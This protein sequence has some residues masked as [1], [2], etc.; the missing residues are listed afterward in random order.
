MVKL[1]DSACGAQVII[2]SNDHC[3]SHVHARHRGEG[4]VVRLA[5]DYLTDEVV[6]M[7]IAPTERMVTRPQI[8][9]LMGEVAD[10][11]GACR[12]AW[13]AIQRTTC[14]ENRRTGV[15]M[16]KSANY[17]PEDGFVTLVFEDGKMDRVVAGDIS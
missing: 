14:L 12:A 4:W 11:I 13:W 17:D 5:F 7:S 9:L 10:A 15:G 16:I 8:K 6:V 2:A 3:P 1:F